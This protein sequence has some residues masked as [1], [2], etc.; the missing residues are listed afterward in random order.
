MI[1]Y[2]NIK[3]GRLLERPDPDPWLEASSGWT[4]HEEPAPEPPEA[5]DPPVDG[6]DEEDD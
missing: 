6:G 5:N 1:V 2:R 4:L 3:T